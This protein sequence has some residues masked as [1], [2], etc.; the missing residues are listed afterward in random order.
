VARSEGLEELPVNFLGADPW[1][2]GLPRV[3]APFSLRAF[4]AP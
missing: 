1:P 4:L 3:T 2:G